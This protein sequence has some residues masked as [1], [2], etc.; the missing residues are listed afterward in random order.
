MYQV[1]EIIVIKLAIISFQK[2][3]TPQKKFMR[4]IGNL[5]EFD[6]LAF[7][8]LGFS[9][10]ERYLVLPVSPRTFYRFR[11]P[12]KLIFRA[13]RREK[14]RRLFF[15]KFSDVKTFYAFD[16]EVLILISCRINV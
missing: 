3:S 13:R 11:F 8:E 5:F 16:L 15:M 2:L 1:A 14:K 12:N 9:S 4:W 10:L 6:I 7:G